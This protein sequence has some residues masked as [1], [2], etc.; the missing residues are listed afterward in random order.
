[1]VFFIVMILSVSLCL[2]GTNNYFT[3]Y[4]GV[5]MK[6]PIMR[7]IYDILLQVDTPHQLRP[8]LLGATPKVHLDVV[9][10]S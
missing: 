9:T 4:F 1:M 10:A 7:R 5:E 3:P 6:I 8:K 2:Y